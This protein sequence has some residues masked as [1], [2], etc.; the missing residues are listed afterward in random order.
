[1]SDLPKNKHLMVF[2]EVSRCGG[3]MSAAKKLHMTQPSVTRIIKELEN[4]IGAPLF[5]RTNSGVYLNQAGNIFHGRILNYVNGLQKSVAEIR[6]KF[7]KNSE[8]FALGYS[9]LVGYTVLPDVINEFKTNH[10]NVAINIYEGQLSS[11]LPMIGNGTIDC[12]IGTVSNDE[13]SYEYYS[14]KLFRSRFAVFSSPLHPLA[15]AKSLSELKS[16]KWVLP[17]T[18]FGYYNELNDF[19]EVH[20]I[21]VSSSIRTD[22]ISS[23]LSLVTS[24]NY[25]TVLASPMG[26]GR[27]KKLSLHEI[28]INEKIPSADYYLIMGKRNIP[29]SLFEDFMKIIKE[30]CSISL[31]GD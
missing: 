8:T 6:E 7:G 21:N 11:L 9:S 23:I 22:S 19:L 18:N 25:L 31:W 14:E 4:H 27:N 1:M 28:Q 29:S 2:L 17:E 16:A 30:R 3:I 26:E 24:A 5:H 15:R 20:G 12:A 13:L 10:K